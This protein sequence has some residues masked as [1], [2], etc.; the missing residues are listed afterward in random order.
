MKK[1]SLFLI[2]A[3]GMSLFPTG[4]RADAT[5]DAVLDVNNPPA[6]TLQTG[7]YLAELARIDIVAAS[8][9]LSLQGIQLGADTA[10]GLSNFANIVL[11]NGTT[12]AVLGEY[13]VQGSTSSMINFPLITIGYQQTKVFY[14][15]GTPTSSAAGVVRV[16]FQDVLL[17]NAGVVTRTHL[18]I[19][20]NAITLPGMTPAPTSTPTP[21]VSATP[22]PTPTPSATCLPRPVCLDST[23][24][25]LLPE[26]VGG[27]CQASPMTFQDG[28]LVRVDGTNPVYVI[29]TINGKTFKRWL[30]S[31]KVLVSYP[32]LIAKPVRVVQAQDLASIPSS[33]LIR[34]STSTRVYALT[35]VQEGI[36]ATRQWIPTYAEFVRLGY[37]MDSV[38]TVNSGEFSQYRLGTNL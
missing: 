19:Y 22:V 2:L 38:Y 3:F 21:S 14:I 12:N 5:V 27:W 6:Q 1:I 36:T 7:A 20:G 29:K 37:D 32:Q 15:R 30:I 24:R 10:N 26:P 33:S 9:D 4:T 17:G 31:Y 11:Y 28:D 8:G 16:G 23:P 35:N 18:P 13:P 25:C 34:L